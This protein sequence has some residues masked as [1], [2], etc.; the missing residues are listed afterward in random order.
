LIELQAVQCTVVIAGAAVSSNG[1]PL[2]IG[3]F[4]SERALAGKL[5]IQYIETAL[6]GFSAHRFSRPKI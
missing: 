6:Y 2:F 1:P 4:Y 5:K 3:A